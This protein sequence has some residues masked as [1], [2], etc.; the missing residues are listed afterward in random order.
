MRLI[1]LSLNRFFRSDLQANLEV[2]RHNQ[3]RSS[4]WKSVKTAVNWTS[5]LGMTELYVQRRLHHQGTG[6]FAIVLKA[7]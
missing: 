6:E 1:R 2:W 7:C 3:E 5:M 4:K